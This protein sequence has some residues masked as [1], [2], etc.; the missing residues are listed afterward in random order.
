MRF[1]C[2]CSDTTCR[3]RKTLPRHPEEYK[4]K[5]AKVRTGRK[6]Y[7]AEDYWKIALCEGCGSPVSLD[8]N[9]HNTK[10]GIV[11][12]SKS[13]AKVCRCDGYHFQH[14]YGSKNCNHREEFLLE[15]AAKGTG[16]GKIHHEEGAPF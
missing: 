7:F 5:S 10:L 9:R 16:A 4:K 11:P 1:S 6:K 13:I 14:G 8:L 12:R 2:K 3:K 15:S